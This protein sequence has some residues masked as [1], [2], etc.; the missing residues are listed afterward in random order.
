MQARYGP[1]LVVHKKKRVELTY[2]EMDEALSAGLC[3]FG[4]QLFSVVEVVALSFILDGGDYVL[5][6]VI[7]GY[8]PPYEKRC[9]KGPSYKH[10]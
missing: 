4:A 3:Q 8:P 1:L 9:Q 7:L 10:R 2:N 5:S 6:S